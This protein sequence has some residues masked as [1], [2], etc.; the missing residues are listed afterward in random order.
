MTPSTA[1]PHRRLGVS[2]DH[3]QRLMMPAGIAQFAVRSVADPS[4]GTCLDDNARAW[5]VAIYALML[6]PEHPVAVEFGDRALHLVESAQRP[7]GAFRNMADAHGHF[8]EDIGSEESIG[9]AVW[10]CGIAARCALVKAWRESA[11]GM[12]ERAMRAIDDLAG[13]HARAYALFGLSA[14]LAPSPAAWPFAPVADP[15][16]ASL[17]IRLL[18]LLQRV[19]V[20]YKVTLDE[21]SRPGW[22][23]WSN[24]LTWG[25]GRL[26]EALL[27]VSMVLDDA[28]LAEAGL[29]SLEFLAEITQPDNMFVPIGNDGWYARG[30]ERAVYDQ[31]PIEACAMTDAWLAA[32]R[33]TGE[34][35]YLEKARVAYSWFEGNNTDKLV[36]CVPETGASHDGLLRGTLNA[37]QG[38][39]STLSYVH[40][41][42]ALTAA[43]SL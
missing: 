36:V 15:L 41:R 14:A 6:D 37:N 1:A 43:S 30:G 27:R 29:R 22:P 16:P 20:R 25:N 24:L 26:P 18:A 2:F 19:V 28:D 21:E 32:Y 4:S 39:E 5:I 12:L 42:L 11:L 13:N 17:R 7:D 3:L 8:V 33:V 9:R 35:S 34:A 31:Q 38:A 40:A 10:A 23:W